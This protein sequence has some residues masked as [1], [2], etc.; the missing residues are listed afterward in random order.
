MI[1]IY[2]SLFLFVVISARLSGQ[3][4]FVGNAELYKIHIKPATGSITIDGVLNEEAWSTAATVEDFWQQSP[5]DGV[6]ASHHTK[7]K[8]TYNDRYLYVAGVCYD[9]S[10]YFVRTLKRD[11]WEASD[12]FGVVL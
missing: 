9:D 6:K 10:S 5:V 2:S 7:A 8:V 1:R 11:D 4:N 12:E 3:E